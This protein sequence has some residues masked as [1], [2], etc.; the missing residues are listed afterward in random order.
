MK[1]LMKPCTHSYFLIAGMAV[2]C[3]A[4]RGPEAKKNV[5]A[6]ALATASIHVH[7]TATQD[8]AA[9][10]TSIIL[11]STDGGL[12]WQDISDGLP[13]NEQPEGFFAG[14]SGV[15]V[16]VKNVMYHSKRNLKTPVWEKENVP[17]LKSR[18]SRGWS[19]TSIA[20]NRSGVMAYNY[21]GQIYQKTSAAETWLPIHT[22]FKEHALRTIFETSDGT[23]FLGYDHGLYKSVDKGKNWKQVQKGPVFNVVESEGVLMATRGTSIMRSTDNGE[24][25]E[26]IISE[27]RVGHFVER[28]DGG[29][30][31]VS[32]GSIT[33]PRR[34]RISLDNG[35]TWKDIDEGLPPSLSISSIKQ[36]GK[37]LICSH[38]DG[39]FRSSDMGKTW[40]RVYTAVEEFMDAFIEVSYSTQ[41]VNASRTVFTIYTSG[42]TLYAVAKIAGC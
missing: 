31:A 3:S 34:I 33:K 23:L 41:R 5:L 21:D 39:I 10:A 42:N 28:I 36:I 17:D 9:A 40:T 18:S 8:V 22:N 2:A 24:H 1:L 7:P 29:F 38:P 6:N 12:T 25:W 15:Y 4:C 27:G 30:V 32:D 37:Y 11:Q 13:E 19:S 16:H 14:E 26:W 20:F 35:E